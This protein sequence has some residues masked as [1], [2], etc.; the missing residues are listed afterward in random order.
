MIGKITGSDGPR[1][2]I[3]LTTPQ[4]LQDMQK[5]GDEAAN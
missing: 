3:D 5:A 4:W 2:P 1:M